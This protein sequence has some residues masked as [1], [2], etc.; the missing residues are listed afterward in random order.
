L[1]LKLLLKTLRL[2]S[3]I[4]QRPL[5]MQ[6]SL[7]LYFQWLL[8]L[9]FQIFMLFLYSWNIF[10]NFDPHHL[11]FLCTHMQCTHIQGWISFTLILVGKILYTWKISINILRLL[12][13]FSHILGEN[14]SFKQCKDYFPFHLHSSQP[15]LYNA[16]FPKKCW[17]KFCCLILVLSGGWQPEASV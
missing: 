4:Y 3:S 2:I 12:I 17:L 6:T 14:S 11:Y 8:F 5:M 13:D 7:K 15:K 9:F 10:N 16:F 1:Q